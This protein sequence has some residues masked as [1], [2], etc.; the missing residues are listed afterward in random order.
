M[1]RLL[2]AI[3]CAV[4]P[5]SP[6]AIAHQDPPRHFRIQVEYIEAPHEM[7]TAVLQGHQSDSGPKIHA[8]MRTHVNEKQARIME[9]CIITARE[10]QKAVLSS[11]QEY[12]YPTENEPPEIPN[13]M[14]NMPA[15]FVLKSTNLL[16]RSTPT[17][18][19]T[20]DLGVTL[21]VEPSAGADA[22][23]IDLRLAPEIV[24]R[25]RLETWSEHIDKLGDASI[26]RPTIEML[27]VRTGIT[28]QCGKWSFV[29]L[30]TP[31]KNDGGPDHDRKIMLFVRANL[32]VMES[33]P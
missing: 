5:G 12:I 24:D 4:L 32:I 1:T 33:A 17:A 6:H 19:E 31:T 9:T 2:I 14:G 15:P 28:L 16:G 27:R 25:L 3:G 22:E 11:I 30:L 20:R 29:T 7:V 10:G 26:T 18:F 13:S 23:I 21:E 8:R